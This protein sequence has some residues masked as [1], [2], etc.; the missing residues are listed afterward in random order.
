MHRQGQRGQL[1]V[2]EMNRP[3]IEAKEA[4]SLRLFPAPL[5]GALLP[6]SH[7]RLHFGGIEK[8]RRVGGQKP[9]TS[10]L[11]KLPC[12][13]LPPAPGAPVAR[14]LPP[15][16]IVGLWL[17]VGMLA[18]PPWL[19]SLSPFCWLEVHCLRAGTN[20]VSQ[21][22]LRCPMIWVP[23]ILNHGRGDYLYPDVVFI[24]SDN[25]CTCRE[26]LRVGCHN[27]AVFQY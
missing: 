9:C 25:Y 18:S 26:D 10:Q 2:Q 3:E 8:Q 13:H 21:E 1:Q 24:V 14:A 19:Q 17:H 23:S 5:C 4:C 6:S 20:A 22:K 7:A 16:P 15:Q 27:E 11:R 12:C